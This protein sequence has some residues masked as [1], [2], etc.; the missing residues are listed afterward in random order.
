MISISI[1]GRPNVG[2]STLFNVLSSKRIAITHKTAGVT[3]DALTYQCLR[4]AYTMCLKDLAGVLGEGPYAEQL[5]KRGIEEIQKSDI[6]LFVV[7]V[8]SLVSEDYEIASIL[9]PF[10]SKVVLVINKVDNEERQW[11]AHEYHSLGIKNSISISAIHK[12]H[13]DTLWHTID[14]MSEKI[15]QA[16]STEV[17]HVPQNTIMPLDTASTVAD[18]LEDS[19]S[20]TVHTLQ[21]ERVCRLLIVGKPN[22]GKSSFF[23]YVLK[24]PQNLVSSVPGTTRDSTLDYIEWNGIRY[25]IVDTAGL[26]R[27]ANVR[28]ELEYFANQRAIEY[29]NS[30]D[31]VLL[32]I[33]VQEGMS[34]QDKKIASLALSRRKSIV[35]CLNKWDLVENKEAMKLEMKER[36]A[37][38]VPQLYFAP[39]CKLSAK[40]GVGVEQLFRNIQIIQNQL[41]TKV[42][43]S[44][45]NRILQQAMKHH[46]APIIKR[47]RA[48]LRFVAQSSTNP[49]CFELHVNAHFLFTES[50][51]SYLIRCIRKQY[52]FTAIPIFLTISEKEN[53]DLR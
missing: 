46:P 34:E 41:S 26:R 43:T 47:R 50:Y 25:G 44:H 1:I 18:E 4:N 23:N 5:T 48:K 30:A 2:K 20:A 36:I 7:S 31:I 37:Y 28:D 33:D 16:R 35:L 21:D 49:M 32:F 53:K 17:E 9:R 10:M 14:T 22:S 24:K 38:L 8:E 29:I 52:N 12:I 15:E 13:I 27:K 39:L 19:R 45:I 40:T 3:R 42:A 51:C 6:I 11:A